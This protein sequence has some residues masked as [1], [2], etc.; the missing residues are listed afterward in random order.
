SYGRFPDGSDIWRVFYVPDRPPSPGRSNGG[1]PVDI[2]I[3]EIM[4]H[5]YHSTSGTI[6]PE[7]IREEYIEIFNKGAA[8]VSL[9][10]WRFSN[11]V[12]FAF[13]NDVTIGSG[14]Y[15]VVAADVATFTAKYPLVTN[16]IGG[17]DGRLSNSGEAIELI[18][19]MDVAIDRVRYAD[20]G[21]WAVRYL[22]PLDRGHRGWLWTEE[23][24]GEGKSLELINPA[25]PNEYGQNWAASLDNGGTP[26]KANSRVMSDVAPLIPDVD[27]RPII[28]GP[29][30]SVIVT[31][32][33][34]DELTSGITVTLHY[35]VDT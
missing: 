12:D 16:V 19:D 27:H 3:N 14:Q 2:V 29:N 17:W 15:L 23:H 30:D 13:P 9:S 20:Q 18:D 11:G 4:Y 6:E 1:Q 35:R 7:D 8:L 33:I 32:R 34:F 22:G 5:P 10:G 28:P 21:E 24:D 31:A 26:G 25:L